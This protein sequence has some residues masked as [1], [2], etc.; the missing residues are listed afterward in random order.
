MAALG[1]AGAVWSQGRGNPTEWPT[2]F[3]D[4][5]HTSWVRT[6]PHISVERMGQPDFG[7]QWTSKLDSPSRQGVSFT[8]GVV[9]PAVNLFTPL[10]TIAGP[11]NLIFALDN[12]TGNPFWTRRFEGPLPAATAACPGGIS[13]APTRTVALVIPAASPVRGG[14][15]RGGRAYGGAVGEPGAGVPL[16]STTGARGGAGGRGAGGQAAPAAPPPAAAPAP[17]P[18]PPAQGAAAAGRSQA[19]GTSAAVPPSPFPTNQAAVAAASRGGGGLFRSSGVLYAVSGDGLF[20]TLGLVSGKDVQRPAPF[21]PAGARF[22]D[23]IAV[24][25]MLYTATSRGC[26]GAPDGIW[27]IATS[28]DP[29]SVVSWKTNGGDPIGSPVFASSGTVIAAIGAGS[30]SNGAYTNAIVALD[31]R[32]LELKDWFKQPGVELASAPVVFQEA[33]RDIVVVTTKDGRVLLLDAASLGGANHATPLFAS[34][35]LTGNGSVVAQSPALWRQRATAAPALA[36]AAPAVSAAPSADGTRW[37]LIPLT[38]A[39]ASTIAATHGPVTTGAIL[40]VRILE[41]AGT[42][43]IQPGWLSE[44]VAAPVTP[45]IVNGVVFTAAGGGGSATRLHAFDGTTGETMWHSGDVMK[46]A[47]SAGSLWTGSGHVFVGTT[48][49]TVYAFGFDM[50]R[51]PLDQ[52]GGS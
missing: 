5:Q 10:S 27:A 25:D 14:G 45:L 51:G 18:A 30:S 29:G 37:L 9:T 24:G 47:M 46:A 39:V 38:G 33:D 22:S 4:A 52:R 15:A 19:T 1:M 32:T 13:G 40:A 21:L 26:G 3:G 6:D 16:P 49:G 41:Q 48:D 42:F 17:Q 12:D 8:Q 50:E 34:A 36:P 28:G 31:P 7:L 44:N 43:S 35:S 11:A 20:R 23:L 2:A